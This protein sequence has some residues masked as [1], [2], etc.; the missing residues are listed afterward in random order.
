M[1]SR[2]IIT[3]A[4][5]PTPLY[6]LVSFNSR[7]FVGGVQVCTTCQHILRV[8]PLLCRN[9]VSLLLCGV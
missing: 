3:A 9:K 4:V 2:V 8:H 6:L 1:Y 7:Y 5:K